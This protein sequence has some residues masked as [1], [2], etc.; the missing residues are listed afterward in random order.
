MDDLL[1]DT[2]VVS[3]LVKPRPDAMVVRFLRGAAELWLCSITFHEL[4]YGAERSPEPIRR[5]KLLAWIAQVKADFATRTVAV[6]LAI[7]E[8]SGRLRALA[9]LQGRPVSVVDA[10]IAAAAQARGLKLATRNTRDFEPFA[11][12]VVNPWHDAG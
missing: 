11:I 1:L 4:A 6:D 5:T 10:L 7:A 2:N 8:S 9:A 12:A 3:E